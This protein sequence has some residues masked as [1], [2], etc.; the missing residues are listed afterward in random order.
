V[1]LNLFEPRE[2]LSVHRVDPAFSM[3]GFPADESDDEDDRSGVGKDTASHSKDSMDQPFAQE[4][5]ANVSPDSQ[6][7]R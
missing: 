5:K 3:H 2:K 7:R 1:L 4:S 6:V